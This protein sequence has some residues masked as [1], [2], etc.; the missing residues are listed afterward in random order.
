MA[1]IIAQP[2]FLFGSPKELKAFYMKAMPGTGQG[3]LT[4]TESCD[5]LMPNVGEIVS[6]FPLYGFRIAL[7]IHQ[8][9][10]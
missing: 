9:A 3:G 5:L 1:D 2:V 10:Q 4:Y 8:A 6:M 7:S